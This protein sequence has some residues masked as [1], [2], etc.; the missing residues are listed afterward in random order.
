MFALVEEPFSKISRK[1]IKNME[2][3]AAASAKVYQ[4][5]FSSFLFKILTTLFYFFNN[6]LKFLKLM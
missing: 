1:V 5:Y 4:N 3:K 2:S 6:T